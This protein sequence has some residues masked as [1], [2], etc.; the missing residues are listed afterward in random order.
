MTSHQDS[1]FLYTTPRQTCLGLWLALED[2]TL[3]NG[4]LWVR[5]GSQEESVRRCFRR[6]PEYFEV[7]K[8]KEG[9]AQMIFVDPRD[10]EVHD[11]SL[12]G[13]GKKKEAVTE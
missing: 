11:E 6:N 4:C 9:A 3:L 1:T 13:I 12:D 2:T 7:N 5:P 10:E 8:A